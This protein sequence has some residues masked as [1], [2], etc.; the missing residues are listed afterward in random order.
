MAYLKLCEHCYAFLKDRQ[1]FYPERFEFLDE[2]AYH[3]LSIKE[4]KCCIIVPHADVAD[5]RKSFFDK[6]NN[7]EIR[8]RYLRILRKSCKEDAAERLFWWLLAEQNLTGDYKNFE[9][10]YLISFAKNWCYK[11]G[12][13]C[14]D[15]PRDIKHA[16]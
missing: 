1:W 13:P 16:R 2:V 5:I 11:Y 9:E 12:I 8:N 14:S 4:Q 10:K 15:K 7:N 6:L 3:A